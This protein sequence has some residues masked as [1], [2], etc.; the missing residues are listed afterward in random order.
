MMRLIGLM[1]LVLSVTGCATESYKTRDYYLKVEKHLPDPTPDN[2][3]H[4]QNYGC[5]TYKMVQ[6]ND[7][8]WRTIAK[9][10][11]PAPRNASEERARIAR[12]IGVFE[13]V[14][15]PI[16]R[17][18]GD[19]AGSFLKTGDGQLDCVDE[20]VNTTLYLML[21]E[22]KGLLRFYSIER[23]QVRWPLVSGRGWMHQTAVITDLKDGASYAVDSW[24][25]DNGRPAYVV[26]LEDWMN[27][28]HPGE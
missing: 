14:I 1:I 5:R 17:T 2:F 21:L 24:Y 23:P 16:T 7:R 10:F 3:P 26:P 18:D 19:I 22:Q 11:T 20:S 28:W 9:S 15:G 27:G 12:T 8:D 4:C 13:Q 25:E 6:L